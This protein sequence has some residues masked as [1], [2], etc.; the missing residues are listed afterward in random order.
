MGITKFLFVLFFCAVL[1]L[2]YTKENKVVVIKKVEK[3]LIEFENSIMY[4]ISTKGVNQVIQSQDAY[5]FKNSE[6][7]HNATILIKSEKDIS[8]ANTISADLIVK[9]KN[10]LYLNNNVVLQSEDKM[11]LKTEELQ[12]NTKSL[13]A[14][15]N[16]EFEI[17]QNNSSFYGVGLFMDGKIKHIKANNTHFR[18]K[19]RDKNETN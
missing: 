17:I 1:F 3:P 8:K 2:F 6:Q 18:I 14:V 13:V 12:Y 11:T 16:S 19:L 7:L 15:N 10:N 4:D 9:V 5:I